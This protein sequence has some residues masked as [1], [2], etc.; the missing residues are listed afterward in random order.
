MGKERPSDR[1]RI[2]IAG[3]RAAVEEFVA[4]LLPHMERGVEQTPKPRKHM[5]IGSIRNTDISDPLSR[6]PIVEMHVMLPKHILLEAIKDPNPFPR[7][8]FDNGAQ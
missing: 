7:D 3:P 6:Q 2:R 5:R 8:L 1:I 4:K